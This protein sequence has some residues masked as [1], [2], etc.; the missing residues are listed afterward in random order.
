M[1]DTWF[2]PD[3]ACSRTPFFT[4]EVGPSFNDDLDLS[5]PDFNFSLIVD[6]ND[7]QFEDEIKVSMTLTDDACT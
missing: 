5:L 6:P 1:E 7:P 4:E 3:L 2:D